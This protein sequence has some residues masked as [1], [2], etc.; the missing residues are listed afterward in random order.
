VLVC[1]CKGV[2]EA[3]IR[4]AVAAGARDEFDVADTCGAGSDCGGCLPTVTAILEDMGAPCDG[5]ALGGCTLRDA[6]GRRA[7]AETP[8]L[9]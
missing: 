5:G 1:H 6:L 2:H 3:R 7:T 4:A 9:G 8:L